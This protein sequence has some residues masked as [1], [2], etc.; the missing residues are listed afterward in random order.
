MNYKYNVNDLNNNSLIFKDFQ[1]PKDTA[2]IQT[3]TKVKCFR[4]KIGIIEKQLNVYYGFCNNCP[5]KSTYYCFWKPQPHQKV[6]LATHSKWLYNFG[7][8]GTGKTEAT[9]MKIFRVLVEVNNAFII[10]LANDLTTARDMM[11]IL[12]KFIPQEIIKKVEGQTRLEKTQDKFT[13]INGSTLQLFSS[14]NPESYRGR[15]ATFGWAIEA[16]KIKRDVL[17]ELIGRIRNENQIVFAKDSQG[18]YISEIDERGMQRNK[19][20]WEFGQVLIETNPEESSWVFKDGLLTCKKIF[21]S[22]HTGNGKGVDEYKS[23]KTTKREDRVAVI[24]AGYDNK[25]A[26]K[27]FLE[28]M[29]NQTEYYRRK[30]LY[31]E[32]VVDGS[33]VWPTIKQREVKNVEHRNEWPHLLAGD[34]GTSTDPVAFHFLYLDP[35]REKLVLWKSIKIFQKSIKEVGY[36]LKKEFSKRYYLPDKKIIDSA[37]SAKNPDWNIDGGLSVEQQLNKPPLNLG[38]TLSKKSIKAGEIAAEDLINNELIEFDTLGEGVLDSLEVLSRAHFPKGDDNTASGARKDIA[39]VV[40]D[41]HYY[42][43]FR[44]LALAVDSIWISEKSEKWRN[45]NIDYDTIIKDR[46]LILSHQAL[47]LVEPNIPSTRTQF[48]INY[49]NWDLDEE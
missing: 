44:Y 25:Y 1:L 28:S 32:F 31:G 9:C 6:V 3:K 45:N 38:I 13:L 49:S 34:W 37:I 27:S 12:F 4:C 20:L 30:M 10:T 18:N 29:D 11:K 14:K 42:D 19:I 33:P 16:N 17:E 5:N 47:D 8:M 7:G 22:Y 39:K 35:Y 26:P 21:Y 23:I 40:A 43:A 41:N 46:K 36:F 48:G 15:N 2:P 24:S